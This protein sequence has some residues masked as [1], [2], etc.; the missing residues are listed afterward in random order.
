MG[1]RRWRRPI[2]RR[3]ALFIPPVGPQIGPTRWYDGVNDVVELTPGTAANLGGG[4]LTVAA[5]LRITDFAEGGGPF[6][7][8]TDGTTTTRLAI[9][10]DSISGGRFIFH[11]GG[12]F[13]QMFTATPEWLIVAV[14]KAAGSSIPRYHKYIFD[15]AAWSHANDGV[16]IGDA[17]ET[18]STLHLGRWGDSGS[19]FMEGFLGGVGA[20]DRVLNDTEIESL[21]TGLQAW[22]DLAPVDLWRPGD[23]PVNDY[24]GTA[25]QVAVTGTEINYY[26]APRGF[27]FAITEAA[28]ES[29]ARMQRQNLRR[30]VL[31]AVRRGQRWEA[32]PF[33]EAVLEERPATFVRRWLRWPTLV[34]RGQR[35]EAPPE[36]AVVAPE[37]RPALFARRQ[38]RWPQLFRRGQRWDAP[39]EAVEPAA[40]E[41]PVTFVR[42]VHRLQ[43]RARRGRFFTPTPSVAQI[44][45][46]VGA[47][48]RWPTLARRGQRW[49]AP[50]VEA[51]AAPEAFIPPTVGHQPLRVVVPARPNR[52]TPAPTVPVAPEVPQVPG[53]V[54][55]EFRWPQ[56]HR[57]GQR[58]DAPPRALPVA[59]GVWLPGNRRPAVQPPAR[60]LRRGRF[61]SPPWEPPVVIPPAEYP[62]DPFRGV[63]GR[64]D[65]FG[66]SLSTSPDPFAAVGPGYDPFL[67]EV[68]SEPYPPPQVFPD[69]EPD[70]SPLSPPEWLPGFVRG[71]RRRPNLVRPSRWFT[72]PV[73]PP[74]DF[75]TEVYEETY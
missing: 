20:W 21:D 11:G 51:P 7:L 26:N 68:I 70:P 61:W 52:W 37:E 53:M 73:A 59:P 43:V 25:D 6:W 62:Y 67:P 15:T 49:E 75:Y 28:P 54:G 18:G 38:L 55:H 32:P 8:G 42:A 44:P 56:L 33:V 34:R 2:T 4:A 16:S 10:V 27:D 19:A 30:H 74:T 66:S 65:P 50:F 72:P 13:R 45:P 64:Y 36:V 5:C 60:A 39:V 23:D 12:T 48:R 24:L 31:P 58:W 22:Y 41:T 69:P 29:P 1:F 9:E 40:P 3:G 14:T 17:T 71:R 63:T 35:W 57:H 46:R 47:R